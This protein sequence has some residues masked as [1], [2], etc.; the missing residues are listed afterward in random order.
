MIGSLI[1]C[2]TPNASLWVPA[3]YEKNALCCTIFERFTSFILDY[4]F[5]T[6][7]YNTDENCNNCD[8]C[9]S[10]QSPSPDHTTAY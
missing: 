4:F 3:I 10:R 8:V 2:E 1:T 7:F 5:G 9:V 6:N